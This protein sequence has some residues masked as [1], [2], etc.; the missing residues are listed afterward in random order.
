MRSSS[1]VPEAPGSLHDWVDSRL[2]ALKPKL[3]ELYGRIRSE[4]PNA[5]ILVLGYPALFPEKAPPVSDLRTGV[6]KIAFS[7][8]TVSER[9][10]IRDWGLRLN[11]EIQTAAENAGI[12][13][14]ELSS[15]FAGH[16]PCSQGGQWVRFV[17]DIRSG[18]IRDDSFH[19]L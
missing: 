9:E 7:A 5:R 3:V 17:D 4:A 8:F 15:Y 1:A 12:E 10:A 16:E 14:V 18:A 2:E 19:P 13:Y 11:R 6:C